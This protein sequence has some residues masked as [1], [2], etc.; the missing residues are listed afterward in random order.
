M[1]NKNII[2]DAIHFK[3]RWPIKTSPVCTSSP[4]IKLDSWY[5]LSSVYLWCNCISAHPIFENLYPTLFFYLATYQY[6]RLLNNLVRKSF[7][8]SLRRL[9]VPRESCLILGG[10]D[11]N[12]FLMLSFSSLTA[13]HLGSLIESVR[14]KPW[15]VGQWNGAVK[16]RSGQKY[17]NNSEPLKCLKGNGPGPYYHWW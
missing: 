9:Y 12:F 2:P 16:N 15:Q 5:G 10:S 1:H 11:L 3:P 4:I 8:L 14:E 17:N 6:L 13:V 7:L